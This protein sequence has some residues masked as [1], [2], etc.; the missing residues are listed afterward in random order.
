MTEIVVIDDNDEFR[1]TLRAILESGGYTVYE[2]RDGREGVLWCQSRPIDL[3]ITD[4]LMPHQEGV[5]TIQELRTMKHPRKIIAISGG[6]QTG[7]MDFLRLAA[8]LGADR[9]PPS[10]LP[11]L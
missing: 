9:T 8:L 5:E 2:A 3:V 7:R 10:P 6:G 1:D 4:I 11:A